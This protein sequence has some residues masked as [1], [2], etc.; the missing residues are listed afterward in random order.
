MI[1]LIWFCGFIIQIWYRAYIYTYKIQMS[2]LKLFLST[3]RFFKYSE[4][5]EN[6]GNHFSFQQW[7][8]KNGASDYDNIT[9]T[10]KDNQIQSTYFGWNGKKLSTIVAKRDI[11]QC[12]MHT[13]P[14][15]NHFDQRLFLWINDHSTQTV[16]VLQ[17][18]TNAFILDQSAVVGTGNKT[19]R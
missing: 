11:T 14:E 12:T 7:R 10:Q 15:W 18:W 17:M 13:G 19:L 16:N 9:F 4:S 1:D 3:S 6:V 8:A 5:I 2:D